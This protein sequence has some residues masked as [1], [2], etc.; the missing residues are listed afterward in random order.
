MIG[1]IA[2]AAMALLV[3]GCIV[4]VNREQLAKE[5]LKADPAFAA[6]LDKHRELTNR[7]A[8]YDRELSLKR[9]NIERSIEQLRKELAAAAAAIRQKTAETK[10]RME[11]DR[12]RLDLELSMASEE[13]KAK[14]FQRATLSRS[15]ATLR[16]TLKSNSV[17]WTP[18]ERAHQ[19]AQL[20]EMLRDAAR[21]DQETAAM[22]AHVRLIKIKL[23]LI[24]L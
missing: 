1:R 18:K 21:M 2:C 16:K 12:K 8:T 17:Q 14:R 6:V 13:L 3:L 20:D 24:K 15:M 10:K 5:V 9:S 11:P 22:R 23:L 19:Q 4:P 7:I